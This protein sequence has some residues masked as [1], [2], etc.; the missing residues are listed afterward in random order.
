MTP[1]CTLMLVG[2]YIHVHVRVLQVLCVRIPHKA[3]NF[4]LKMTA[5]GK[6]CSVALFFCCV[7]LPC[8]FS[9]IYHKCAVFTPTCN[10]MLTDHQGDSYS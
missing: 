1:H 3:A 7:V 5:F 2:M 8:P 10:T 4:S 9:V 6:L